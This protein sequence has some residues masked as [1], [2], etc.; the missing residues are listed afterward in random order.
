MAEF[1]HPTSRRA[2]DTRLTAASVPSPDAEWRR[3]GGCATR[4]RVWLR[5]PRHGRVFAPCPAEVSTRKT[6]VAAAWPREPSPGIVLPGAETAAYPIDQRGRPPPMTTGP[7]TTSRAAANG[8]ELMLGDE[9]MVIAVILRLAAGL[10]YLV[11]TWRRIVQPNPVSWLL[12][13]VTPLIAF[14]AQVQEGVTPQAW[15]VFTLGAGPLLVFAVS[16][17]RKTR[18][19]VTRFDA[20]CGVSAAAGIVLWQLTSNPGLALLFSIVADTLASVPTLTKAY[21]A[22]RSERSLPYLVSMTS[23]ILI[24]ATISN[25]R[26]VDY[27]FPLYMLSINT[28]I[29][30]VVRLRTA[31]LDRRSPYQ[32]ATAAPKPTPGVSLGGAH[33]RRGT[34]HAVVLDRRGVLRGDAAAAR[35]EDQAT[36]FSGEDTRGWYLPHDLPG[37]DGTRVAPE[38]LTF[39]QSVTPIANTV[40]TTAKGQLTGRHRANPVSSLRREGDARLSRPPREFTRARAQGSAG[41]ECVGE[42]S[43]RG[44]TALVNGY[45]RSWRVDLSATIP[46]ERR[47]GGVVTPCGGPCRGKRGH[48]ERR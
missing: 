45:R 10:G 44:G 26:L 15:A 27:A 40:S 43:G 12:W 37:I 39:H 36:E 9:Y 35:H 24:L 21:K 25:P 38:H 42:S 41:L 23:M 22:P 13:G 46:A 11:V 4:Q 17:K 5:E 32:V 1:S 30:S 34:S 2:G 31:Q 28:A 3:G 8:D 47:C 7:A 20:L 33:E 48:D 6:V 14:V 16:V 18:W 29:F 19:R